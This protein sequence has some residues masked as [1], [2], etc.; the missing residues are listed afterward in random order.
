MVRSLRDPMRLVFP[1]YAGVSPVAS[2]H[3]DGRECLPRLRGG[4]P[5]TALSSFTGG[6]SSPPTRG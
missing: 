6:P 5:V 1:A 4:E 2:I 3:P